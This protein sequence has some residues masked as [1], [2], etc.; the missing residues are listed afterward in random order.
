MHSLPI[1]KLLTPVTPADLILTITVGILPPARVLVKDLTKA[2][3]KEGSPNLL[4][5]TSKFTGRKATSESAGSH[6]VDHQS[7]SKDDTAPSSRLDAL[8]TCSS[9]LGS[10]GGMAG[11]NG[12]GPNEPKQEVA[13]LAMVVSD[14]DEFAD[15]PNQIIPTEDIFTIPA[16]P[17]DD[18]NRFNEGYLLP[19]EVTTF[20]GIYY[21]E[22]GDVRPGYTGASPFNY[23]LDCQ[24]HVASKLQSGTAAYS[25][26][27]GLISMGIVYP[28]QEDP[29]IQIDQYNYFDITGS[30]PPTAYHGIWGCLHFFPLVSNVFLACYDSGT[31]LSHLTDGGYG[32]DALESPGI[33]MYQMSIVAPMVKA[34]MTYIRFGLIYKPH[35]LFAG[36]DEKC[37][38][39]LRTFFNRCE[40]E[41][42]VAPSQ[43]Y[44]L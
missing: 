29:D 21:H 43:A 22:S 14:D 8:A 30:I 2:T 25:S 26:Y 6:S 15:D 10:S 36:D 5:G 16:I 27:I 11:G 35:G 41:I 3:L 20:R 12:Q 38:T 34:G 18:L 23:P 40:S 19:A 33:D 31:F 17:R 42:D 13:H 32:F 9:T 24:G 4:K 39:F 44:F 1:S 37:A 7:G 28:Q